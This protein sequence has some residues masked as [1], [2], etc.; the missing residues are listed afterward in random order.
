M[1]TNSG[2]YTEAAPIVRSFVDTFE[3]ALDRVDA[4]VMPSGSCTG[5]VRD[6]HALVARH[7]GDTGLE[8]RAAAV[9]AKTYELSEL[10]TDVLGVN[11]LSAHWSGG[12]SGSDA[13]MADA[14]DALIQLQVATRQQAR[15]ARD[16]ETADAIRDALAAA[17]ITVEDTAGGARWSLAKKEN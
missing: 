15:A 7:E 11:P 5:C 6:Q 4:I 8:E 13:E 1:H 2:Y 9:A 10:L 12:A 16:F 17:G 14:L 3:P